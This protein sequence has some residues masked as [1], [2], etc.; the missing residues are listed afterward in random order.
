MK[1]E[2]VGIIPSNEIASKVEKIVYN[3]ICNQ[4]KMQQKIIIK[5]FFK[6]MIK[7]C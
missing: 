1:H 2:K 6:K 4:A 5:K 7:K 3:Y